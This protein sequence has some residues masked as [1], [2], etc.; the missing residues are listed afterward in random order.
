MEQPTDKTQQQLHSEMVSRLSQVYAKQIGDMTLETALNVSIDFAVAS[1][2][3][4]FKSTGKLG[5]LRP[6]VVAAE[7]ARRLGEMRK[8]QK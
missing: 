1:M 6:N 3:Y 8:L 7:F 5:T 4:V 2:I